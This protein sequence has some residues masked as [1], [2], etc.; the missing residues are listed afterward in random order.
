[1][2]DEEQNQTVDEKTLVVRQERDL[3]IQQVLDGLQKQS[4]EKNLYRAVNGGCAE[5]QR[6]VAS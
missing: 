6:S 3:K 4:I 1:M 2:E 5:H